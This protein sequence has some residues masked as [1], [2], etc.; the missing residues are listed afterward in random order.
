L[1]QFYRRY[2]KR[3]ARRHWENEAVMAQPASVKTP[4]PA[5]KPVVAATPSDRSFRQPN[6]DE[7]KLNDPT[8]L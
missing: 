5:R 4:A 2:L 7:I 1:H 3:Q 6:P 8:K